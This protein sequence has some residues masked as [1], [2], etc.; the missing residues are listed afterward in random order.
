M[1][2]LAEITSTLQTNLPHNRIL[3]I[4]DNFESKF[5]GGEHILTSIETPSHLNSFDNQ[6]DQLKRHE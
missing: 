6:M 3:P 2:D 5:N 1:L 4:P